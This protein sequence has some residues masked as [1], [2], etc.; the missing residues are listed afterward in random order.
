VSE[1]RNYNAFTD[2]ALRDMLAERRVKPNVIARMDRPG[3]IRELLSSDKRRELK[4]RPK[5]TQKVRI[6]LDL[7]L[8]EPHDAT[9]LKALGDWVVGMVDDPDIATAKWTQIIP[10]EPDFDWQGE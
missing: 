3:M 4:Q 7:E 10:T 5:T 8:A 1:T 9:G 2:Q 6:H